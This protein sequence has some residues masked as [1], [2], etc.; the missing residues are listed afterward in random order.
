VSAVNRDEPKRYPSL[1]S[2][3]PATGKVNA[4]TQFLRIGLG[5]YF[6]N[7]FL[8]YPTIVQR[9]TKPL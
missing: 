4:V 3:G 1:G 7:A 5:D 2:E 9:N 8:L 6:V